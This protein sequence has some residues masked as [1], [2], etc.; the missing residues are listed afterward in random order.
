M[1]RQQISAQDIAN[2]QVSLATGPV[3]VD[4]WLVFTA[5]G[6]QGWV[7]ASSEVLEPVIR[8]ADPD[9]VFNLLKSHLSILGGGPYSYVN[10]ASITGLLSRVD[11]EYVLSDVGYLDVWERRR[12]SL[13]PVARLQKREPD[14]R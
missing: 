10:P 4:G 9:A 7:A 12:L 1:E 6:D 13:K 8:F 5:S 3:L 14:D 11:D 2:G